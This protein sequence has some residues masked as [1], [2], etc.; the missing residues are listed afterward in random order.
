MG[1]VFENKSFLT[2]AIVY[3]ALNASSLAEDPKPTLF[4]G[5]TDVVYTVAF[6]PDAQQLLSGSQ[7]NS[8]RLWD[9]KTGKQTALFAGHSS[10]VV[11]AK[12]SPDGSLIAS[13]DAAGNIKI[14]DVKTGKATSSIVA[15]IPEVLTCLRHSATMGR[16]SLQGEWAV[17]Y[18]SGM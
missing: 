7:D 6:S 10:W 8:I 1:D 13:A 17:R 18:R 2:L 5:H 3:L 11:A 12:F 9:V 4:S 16:V 14:W 15:G